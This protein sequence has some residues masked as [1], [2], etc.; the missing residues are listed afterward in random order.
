MSRSRIRQC[1]AYLLITL[2]P[3]QATAASPLALCAELTAVQLAGL[4]PAMPCKQMSSMAHSPSPDTSTHTGACWLGSICLAGHFLMP[5]P[6]AFAGMDVERYS[7]SYLPEFTFYRSI[8]SD[9]PLR[10]PAIL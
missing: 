8:V 3:L 2:L 7:P 4:K 10:P 9:N 6:V 5:I 1:I